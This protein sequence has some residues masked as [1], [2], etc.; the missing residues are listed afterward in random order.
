MRK[1]FVFGGLV[2]SALLILACGETSVAG[3]VVGSSSTHGSTSQP[4]AKHFKVGDVVN[5]NNTW[6]ITIQSFGVVQGD[7]FTQPNQ[8]NK[9][10]AFTVTYKNISTSEQEAFGSADWQLK[11]ATGQTY[12]S[13][14]VS[15]VAQEPMGKVEAG[16]LLKGSIVY[17]VPIAQKQFTLA[18]NPSYFTSGQV[19]WDVT[20]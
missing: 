3:S 2:I 19:I 20:A 5:V 8:G 16:D 12:N 4:A 11:D 13:T 10:V 6:Q 14:F 7:Q 15:T 9:Y 18:F 17:E 1:V